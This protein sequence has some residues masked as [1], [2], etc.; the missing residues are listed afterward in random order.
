MNYI[1]VPAI[2][3]NEDVIKLANITSKKN[4]VKKQD[5][6]CVLESSKS[7]FDL[8]SPEDGFVYFLYDEG[9]EIKIGETLAV[10]SKH[11]LTKDI[12]KQEKNKIKLSNSQKVSK[13]AKKIMDENNISAE[14]IDKKGIINSED[15]LGYLNKKN[16]NKKISKSN[17]EEYLKLEQIMKK[18]IS[19]DS[20]FTEIQNLKNNL[21]FV[22]KT[23]QEKWNRFI[24]PFDIIFDRWAN[25]KN[26]GFHETSNVS[27]LSYIIGEVK[28]GKNCFIG[29][30][31]ILDGSA[32]LEIGDNTSIAA[33]VHIYSHDS[34]SRALSGRKFQ[35]SFGEVK[36]GNNCFIGPSA[37]IT[38]GV[39]VG[40]HCFLGSNSVLT[41]NLESYQAASGNPCEVIGIIK[42]DDNGVIIEKKRSY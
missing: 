15:V 5:L 25:A 37:V 21:S 2:T 12:I 23:Y 10:I 24:P 33:G 3:A 18:N 30:Y 17:S 1:K 41:F 20:N 7:S 38:K 39:Q 42:I 32:G 13:K 27:S 35:Q 34:I 31:T 14:D 6:I 19:N 29:P 16:F 4:N 8:E 40:D 28:V 36:I 9:E 22:Q 26:Y 11:E